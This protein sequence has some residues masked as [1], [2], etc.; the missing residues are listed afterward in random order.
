MESWIIGWGI[1]KPSVK[2]QPGFSVPIIVVLEERG[3]LKES[4]HK[5][6]SQ[7]KDLE[8]C[9]LPQRWGSVSGEFP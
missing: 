9:P 2:G 4:L 5:E 8:D 7:L 6:E 3:K 1:S